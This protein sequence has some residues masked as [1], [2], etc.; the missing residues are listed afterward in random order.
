MASRAAVKEVLGLSCNCAG[1]VV[2]RTMAMAIE[3]MPHQKRMA[4]R[5]RPGSRT[6]SMR[7]L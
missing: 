1:R 5:P 7:T 6:L 3:V 4:L 2:M